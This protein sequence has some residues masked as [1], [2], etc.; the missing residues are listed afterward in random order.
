M[1]AIFRVRACAGAITSPDGEI[2][3]V[4]LRDSG[5]IARAR[6]LTGTHK[7]VAGRVVAG[8]GGFNSPWSWHLDPNT[9][10]FPDVTMEVCDACPGYVEANLGTWAGAMYCPWSAEI[11]GEQ[12]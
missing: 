5:L 8:D 2:F 7:I 9:V 12:K 3:R 4:L 6:A 10:Q 1:Q 11:L